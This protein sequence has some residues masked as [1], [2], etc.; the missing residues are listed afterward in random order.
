MYRQAIRAKAFDATRGI[1]PAAALSNVGIYG[2]GQAFEALLLR[3]RAHPLPEARQYADLMLTE[4]RK[5]IPSF[6]RRVDLPDRGVAWSEYLASTRAAMEATAY[7]LLAGDEVTEPSAPSVTLVDW[8]PEG[9]VKVVAAML[10]PYT[11]LPETQLLDRVRAMS[12]EDRLSVMRAY[13]GA[14]EPAPQA[15]L[16]LERTDYRRHRIGLRGLPGPARH[17]LATIE[18]QESRPATGTRSGRGGEAGL[19]DRFDEAMEISRQLWWTSRAVPSGLT[20][21]RSRTGSVRMQFNARRRCTS[22]SC[23]PRCRAPCTARGP[24]EHRLIASVPATGRSRD[25]GSGP[26]GS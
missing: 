14:H 20:R 23:G 21:W 16:A 19:A 6:L 8:D 13:V 18:W 25:D 26:P 10:Y 11:G 3:M 1:L 9:E 7:E 5:V 4:L 15:R 2:S 22:S 24:G 17:R 12:I